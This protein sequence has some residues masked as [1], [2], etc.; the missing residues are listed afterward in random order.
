[1][2]NNRNPNRDKM[3]EDILNDF[4]SSNRNSSASGY[5]DKRNNS[6]SSYSRS[7]PRKTVNPAA[8]SSNNTTGFDVSKVSESEN[9]FNEDISVDNSATAK[10]D[11]P[12]KD[13][14]YNEYPLNMEK[15]D[16]FETNAA[17]NEPAE[18]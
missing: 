3:L 16:S 7:V 6:R 2:N 13:N 1:M 11:I 14:S 18:N 12:E 9:T 15:K 4:S 10:M 5:S 17:M 8:L